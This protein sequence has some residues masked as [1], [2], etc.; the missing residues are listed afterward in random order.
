MLNEDDGGCGRCRQRVTNRPRRR[1]GA[2]RL[3]ARRRPASGVL[4][5]LECRACARTRFFQHL[6]RVELPLGCRLAPLDPAAGLWTMSLPELRFLDIFVK[7]ASRNA[8]H[9]ADSALGAS[10]DAEMTC[11]GQH[12]GAVTCQGHA[13]RRPC[14]GPGPARWQQTPRDAPGLSCAVL[15]GVNGAAWHERHPLAFHTRPVSSLAQGPC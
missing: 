1:T 2:H 11:L 14:Q 8:S 7:C 6:A 13:G 15:T 10:H 12:A 5:D 9:M 4:S 3:C